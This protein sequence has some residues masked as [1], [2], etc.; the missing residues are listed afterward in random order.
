MSDTNA[1]SEICLRL[2]RGEMSAVESYNHALS[3]FTEGPGHA[4]LQRIQHDHQEN[5]DILARHLR[6]MGTEPSGSSGLWGSFAASAE[7]TATV[8]GDAV[9]LTVLK[10]G[11]EHGIAQY[12]EALADDQVMEEIK[13]HIRSTLLPSLKQHLDVLTALQHT[14]NPS[15]PPGGLQV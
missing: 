3:R 1:C 5:C 15:G 7:A 11:E 12:E 13:E 6:A 2:H 10:Q 8:L 9:T 4:D 14:P